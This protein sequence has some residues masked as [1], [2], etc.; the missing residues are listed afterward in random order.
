MRKNTVAQFR[1]VTDDTEV[2]GTTLHATLDATQALPASRAGI[3]G[4]AIPRD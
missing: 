3:K 4:D 2:V 1:L